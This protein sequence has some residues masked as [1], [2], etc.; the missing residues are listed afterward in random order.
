[1]LKNIPFCFVFSIWIAL[2]FV[3]VTTKYNYFLLKRCFEVLLSSMTD[4][5]DFNLDCFKCIRK[6]MISNRV[7]LN[8]TEYSRASP[9]ISLVNRKCFDL[10]FC[11]SYIH[12][13]RNSIQCSARNGKQNHF[14][15]IIV[16]ALTGFWLM[17]N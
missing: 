16:D 8:G 15:Q 14:T 11:S 6:S 9:R 13:Y 7:K 10:I 5:P 12:L 3:C 2:R 4:T 1:M 17:R